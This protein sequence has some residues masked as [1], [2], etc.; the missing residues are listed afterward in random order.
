MAFW[1]KGKDAAI[2]GFWAGIGAGV[3]SA[4]IGGV[5]RVLGWPRGVPTRR[6]AAGAG[7]LQ[8]IQEM[9][10][11]ET[12]NLRRR[13]QEALDENEGEKFVALLARIPSD[14][15]GGRRVALKYLNDLPDQRFDQMMR[16]LEY[17][18][19]SSEKLAK[20]AGALADWFEG[21][22]KGKTRG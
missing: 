5:G 3:G 14:P 13:F 16:L 10:G 12:A 6:E 18:E 4:L 11:S 20:H 8:D 15:D 9:P 1:R 2:A 7:I 19:S 21:S 22:K 17:P